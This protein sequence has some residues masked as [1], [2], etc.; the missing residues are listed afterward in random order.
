MNGMAVALGVTGILVATAGLAAPL[1]TADQRM[2]AYFSIW[3]TNDSITLPVVE[4][5]YARRIDYYGRPMT[6]DGVYRDKRG[7]VARWPR[8]RYDVVPGS[9][10][11]TCD[12]G[13][14]RCRVTA[15]LRWWKADAA[16]RHASGGA[17]TITL[18]LVRQDG[19]LKIARESGTAVVSAPCEAMGG[20]GCAGFR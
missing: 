15:V 16:G 18:D 7:Y 5:Y 17:S 12:V 20:R 13:E 2:D 10:G 8:R 6:A 4:R 19:V 11:K 9:V 1:A 14:T 3:A